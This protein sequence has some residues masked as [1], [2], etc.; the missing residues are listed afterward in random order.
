MKTN[1][2]ISMLLI[3]GAVTGFAIYVYY[4]I[5]TLSKK[6]NQKESPED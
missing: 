6:E 5:L 3:Q 1:A 2:I 4:K